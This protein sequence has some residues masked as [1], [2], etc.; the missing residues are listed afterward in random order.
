MR[1]RKKQ[2]LIAFPKYGS[3]ASVVNFNLTFVNVVVDPMK[4]PRYAALCFICP[5]FCLRSIL[6]RTWECC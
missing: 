3:E 2:G 1:S 6:V 4:N 5:D